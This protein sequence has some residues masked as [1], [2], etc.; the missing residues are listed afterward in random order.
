MIVVL[1]GAV[2]LGCE[3]RDQSSEMDRSEGPPGP[4]VAP[5]I[6]EVEEIH[7]RPAIVEEV[8][9]ADGDGEEVP[10]PEEGGGR[11]TKEAFLA[12]MAAGRGS[13]KPLTK[14]QRQELLAKEA[15][16][17]ELKGKRLALVKRFDKDGDGE[18]SVAE[19]EAARAVLDAEKEKATTRDRL[20]EQQKN[21]ET[22]RI[23]DVEGEN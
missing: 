20:L 22:E 3:K 21:L 6:P 8:P 14:E 23:L 19:A 4:V 9:K 18:L 11:L 2:P 12:R 5:N 7:E 15:M 17:P 10:L 1:L 16:Q 13:E